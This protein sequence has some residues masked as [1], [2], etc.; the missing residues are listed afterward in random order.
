MEYL[1]LVRKFKMMEQKWKVLRVEEYFLH[2]STSEVISNAFS[3]P[4]MCLNVIGRVIVFAKS[5]F[6]GLEMKDN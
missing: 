5:K 3:E 2:E 6:V 1:A 4:Q